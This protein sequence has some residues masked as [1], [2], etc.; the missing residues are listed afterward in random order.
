MAAVTTQCTVCSSALRLPDKR[1]IGR[2]IRCPRCKSKF[3]AAIPPDQH[4]QKTFA[5]QG[6]HNQSPASE[7]LTSGLSTVHNSPYSHVSILKRRGRQQ[8]VSIVWILLFLVTLAGTTMTWLFSGG[9]KTSTTG[10][11]TLNVTVTPRDNV[12]TVDSTPVGPGHTTVGP[13]NGTTISMEYI[14]IVPHLMLHLRP[15]QIQTQ[16]TNRREITATLGNLGTWLHDF[17]EHTTRFAP[18]EIQELTIAV[19]F[20]ARTSTPTVAAVTRLL[21][22]HPEPEV[23]L[24]RIR[25]TQL[26]DLATKLYQSE[27]LA[28]MVIDTKTIAVCSL[29]VAEDLADT[30][31]YPAVPHPDMEAL[32]QVSDRTR[33]L[34]LLADLPVLEVHKNLVLIPQLHELADHTSLWFGSVSRMMSG[35]IHL[36]PHLQMELKLTCAAEIGPEALQRRM[37]QQVDGLSG[38][39]YETVRAMRPA[40]VGHRKMI[41]RFPA[42]IQAVSAATQIRTSGTG[43]V[44]TTILPQKAAGNLCAG[45][46]LTWNQ[47][48]LAGGHQSG[49][50][51]KIKTAKTGSQSVAEP[52][53]QQVLVDF[54]REPLHEALAYLSRETGVIMTIDGDALRAAGFTQN[55]PQTH[56]LGTVSA[57]K[58]LHMILMKYD[59]KLVIV[60]N[61]NRHSALLTTQ[62]AANAQGLTPYDTASAD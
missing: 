15:A 2:S 48:V 46:T 42:M 31:Q 1:L 32:L 28:F 43:V 11:P 19:N 6:P 44:L 35:S 45:A 61:E 12:Q 33:H 50:T 20:G 41:G 27:D 59:G 8:Q 17:I 26:P 40:T 5:R 49:T 30:K 18:S 9:E 36:D 10:T 60:L 47:S 37:R 54:R 7:S 34:T 21:N 23:L 39:L 58:A 3:V 38:R 25:G 52:L 16:E 4:H 62:D 13:T 57:V 51:I 56:A 24:K 14:P 22:E 55:M 53:H 29:D